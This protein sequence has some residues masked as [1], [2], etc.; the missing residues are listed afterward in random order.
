MTQAR[1]AVPIVASEADYPLLREQLAR[2]DPPYLLRHFEATAGDYERI[3]DDDIKCEFVDGELIVHSPA[4]LQ[5]ESLVSF[6]LAL[7]REHAVSKRLGAVYGSNAV[8]QLG[9]RR[10]SPD[11]SVLCRKHASQ[12]RDG[13]CHG[14]ID[15]VVQGCQKARLT[16]TDR[17]G[18]RRTVR[19]ACAKSG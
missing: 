12:E 14:P 7:L 9:Q 4:T 17:P 15:V 5:H 16:T 8:M 3:A 11:V 19:G 1:P 18:C 10:F 2:L 6:V 13:R